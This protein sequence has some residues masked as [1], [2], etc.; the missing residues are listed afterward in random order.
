M[1]LKKCEVQ[2]LS[3]LVCLGSAPT[4]VKKEKK[5]LKWKK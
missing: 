2:V 5:V 3:F 4:S 1:K